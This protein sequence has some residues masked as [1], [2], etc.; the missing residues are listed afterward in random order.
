MVALLSALNIR[1][2]RLFVSLHIRFASVPFSV[3]FRILR[4]AIS[5][6]VRLCIAQLLTGL[7]A[8]TSSVSVGEVT[9]DT[10]LSVSAIGRIIP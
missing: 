2:R 10:M 9:K 6:C 8:A 1:A 7:H 3:A 4:S 5:P